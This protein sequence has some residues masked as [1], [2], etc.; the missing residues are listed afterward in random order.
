[1]TLTVKLTVDLLRCTLTFYITQ[2]NWTQQ[3]L[4]PQVDPRLQ[5]GIDPPN[6]N[7]ADAPDNSWTWVTKSITR[8]TGKQ[9]VFWVYW[10]MKSQ[11]SCCIETLWTFTANIRLHSFMSTCVYLVGTTATEFLLTNVTREPSTFT[12]WLQ[13]MY[14]ELT[15]VFKTFCWTVSTWVHLCIRMNTNML[16]QFNVSLKQFPTV[17]TIIRSTG[18]VYKS[19][20]CL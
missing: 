3:K 18:A 1:M 11:F 10:M 20:M 15:V 8:T 19:F 13:Q 9:F 17:T 5:G 14:F 2:L 4:W 12:M 7:P 16:L 6:Q